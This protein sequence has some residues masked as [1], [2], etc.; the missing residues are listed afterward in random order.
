MKILFLTEN[1][2]PETSAAAVRGTADNAER[3][4]FLGRRALGAHAGK[5]PALD[6]ARARLP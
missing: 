6:S 1:S 4:R 2:T 5:A 3:C